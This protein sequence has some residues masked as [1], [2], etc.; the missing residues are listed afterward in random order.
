MTTQEIVSRIRKEMYSSAP[1][2]LCGNDD[3]GQM[4]AWYIF[5][6]LGFYPVTPGSG[7]F[8][9]GT[10]AVKRAEISLPNGNK[11]VIETS[12][13][14]SENIYIQSVMLNGIPY[15]KTFLTVE[16]IM[17]GATVKFTMGPEPNKSWGTSSEN[18]PIAL[19]Y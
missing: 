6:A 12:N 9:I 15:D 13:Y 4:S 17:N 18:R 14:S 8:V 16:D 10:P 11:F 2:G 3:C 1:D 19:I 7:Y 5:S